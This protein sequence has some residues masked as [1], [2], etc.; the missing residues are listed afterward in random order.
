MIFA[1]GAIIFQ[2]DV[3]CV[4]ATG[5]EMPHHPVEYEGRDKHE[6]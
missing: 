3:L 1:R 2:N 4:F 5:P 6:D